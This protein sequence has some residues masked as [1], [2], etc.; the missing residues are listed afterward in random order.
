MATHIESL[1]ETL[2]DWEAFCATVETLASKYRSEVGD[3]ILDSTSSRRETMRRFS[4]Q[5]TP[6]ASQPGRR[7]GTFPESEALGGLLR[8]LG[9]PSEAVFRA[10]EVDGGIRSLSQQRQ[11]MLDGMHSYAMASDSP[12]ATELLPTDRA[13][14]L[15]FSSL[16]ADSLCAASLSSVEH[17]RSLSVL[18]SKL[19]RIQKG[20][21]NLNQDVVYQRD[22][23]QE[24]FLE[25]WG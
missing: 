16:E 21:Q 3:Q 15:L 1:I 23:N 19:S 12:L 22:K 2:Q 7:S 6:V 14:R 4:T 11:H 24:K 10:E 5:P 9:L 13:I 25:K 17:E 8:R 20:I 18:E